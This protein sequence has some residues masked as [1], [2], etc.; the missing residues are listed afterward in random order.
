MDLRIV[1]C[2]APSSSSR[3]ELGATLTRVALRLPFFAAVGGALPS[4]PN[5]G[6]GSR[7]TAVV[8]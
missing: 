2:Y 7:R 4:L 1:Q 5:C 6:R 8:R 3:L